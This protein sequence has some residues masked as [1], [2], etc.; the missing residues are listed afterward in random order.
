[1]IN[2]RFLVTLLSL[3][4]IVIFTFEGCKK[5]SNTHSVPSISGFTP[6]TDTIGATITITGNNFSTTAAND[7]VKINGVA[8]TVLTATA[9]EL[10][11]TV[12]SGASNG[13]I[14]VSVNG[15][16]ATSTGSFTVLGPTI[17]GF[18][19]SIS[20]IGYPVVITGTNF[21]SDINS[22]SVT[23]NGSTAQVTAASN[24]QL[25]VIVPLNASTGKIA[26]AVKGQLANSTANILVKKL[27]VTSIAGSGNYSFSDG[28]GTGASFN[29]PWGIVG[30]GN[31]NYYVGDGFNSRIRKV[32][33]AGVVTT[34]SGTNFQGNIDGPVDTATFGD[35][36]GIA[37]D[38]HGNLFVT[39]MGW[40]DIRKITPAGMVSTF[41]G[42]P[43]GSFGT[44][45]GTGTAARFH[46]PLGIT[47]D[48]NDNIFIADADN[49]TIRKITPAGEVTTF[50]GS[51]TKG[52]ADGTGT[53]ASFNQ[54][55]GLGKDANG[56]IYVVDAGNNNI[57]KIT[58]AGVVTTFAGNGTQGAA[59]GPALSASFHQPIGI[60]SDH[61]G[62]FY[63]TDE[64][65]HRIRMITADGNVVT[66]GGNGQN[67]SVDG[68]GGFAGFSYPLGICIDPDD[69]MYL[70]DNGSA[71][72]RKVVVQ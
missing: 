45:D 70:I 26:I 61:A 34:V 44:A 16:S 15:Q 4:S 55:F 52:S 10:V 51:G 46:T 37:I 22:N 29:G 39:T 24:T 64:A 21:S 72:V 71:K 66:V 69:T 43:F 42:D 53:A 56:N 57:R 6:M 3:I 1:M 40:N 54:P 62:N 13:P 47:I 18:S 28:T 30:D 8:A 31:G 14:S 9:T 59:D 32:T 27:T 65:A 7:I 25:T 49:R 20:G 5:D 41:A 35:P 12:P 17:T 68:V 19:P 58:Q 48:A 38:S 60:V 36:F 63:V 67:A 33:A 23:I 50:V 11:V 2:N